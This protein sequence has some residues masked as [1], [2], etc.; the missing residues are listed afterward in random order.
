[1]SELNEAHELSPAGQGHLNDIRRKMVAKKRLEEE[2]V[3]LVDA[4][5]EA[6]AEARAQWESTAP[7]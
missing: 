3:D 6:Y 2:I 5:A 7:V 4:A 1:M